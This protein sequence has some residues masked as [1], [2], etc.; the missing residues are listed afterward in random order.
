MRGVGSSGFSL[1]AGQLDRAK[2]AIEVLSTLATES[3]SRSGSDG[4][5]RASSIGGHGPTPQCQRVLWLAQALAIL[6][7]VPRKV[8]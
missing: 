2:Q 7:E 5:R 6:V 3:E 8:R 1:T 4:R